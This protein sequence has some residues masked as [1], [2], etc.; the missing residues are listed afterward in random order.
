MC[1]DHPPSKPSRQLSVE[2]GRDGLGMENEK[3][4]ERGEKR[5]NKETQKRRKETMETEGRKSD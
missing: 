5:Q 1:R 3:C 2:T 4:E